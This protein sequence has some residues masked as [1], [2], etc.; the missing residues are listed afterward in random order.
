MQVVS[1]VEKCDVAAYI[2]VEELCECC[3]FPIYGG[4]TY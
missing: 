4:S 1:Y 3:S 2:S